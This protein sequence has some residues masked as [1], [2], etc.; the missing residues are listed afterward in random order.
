MGS[1]PQIHFAYPDTCAEQSMVSEDLI[2]TLG[3]KVEP[4]I[5]VVVAIDGGCVACLGLSPVEVKYQGR[6]TQ[7]RLMVKDKL[8]DKVI[9]SKTVLESLEVIDPDFQNAKVRS[10]HGL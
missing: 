2:E 7:T 5:K 1:S 8:K 3:L 10:C 9:L 6:N 4:S